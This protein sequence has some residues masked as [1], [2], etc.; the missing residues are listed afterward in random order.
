MSEKTT[1]LSFIEAV[2]AAQETGCKISRPCKSYEVYLSS[3]GYNLTAVHYSGADPQDYCP[4]VEDIRS[5]DWEIVVPDPPEMIR[6]M[7]FGEAMAK[8]KEGTCVRRKDWEY[9]FIAKDNLY[10]LD[11]INRV[12]TKKDAGQWRSHFI[13]S[14]DEIEATDWIIVEKEDNDE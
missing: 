9:S 4:W 13:P 10:G 11:F 6:L 14:F 7:S 8:V 3:S 1:G 12:Q 5:D 2:R